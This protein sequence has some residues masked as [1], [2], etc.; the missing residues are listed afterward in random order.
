LMNVNEWHKYSS[1]VSAEFQLTDEEGKE[2][3]RPAVKG[4]HFRILIHAH[5]PTD[6]HGYDWV[7]IEKIEELSH[8]DQSKE[9]IAIRVRPSPT[10]NKKGEN[11]AHFFS[12]S[13]TSS[14]VVERDS[15]TVTA[16]VYG[17][18]E[19]P[20]TETTTLIDKVR[21]AIVGVTAIVGLSNVQWKNLVKG[22]IE[23]P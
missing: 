20:N 5:G 12:D 22:L 15:L 19:I 18:N 2:V 17:R 13:S 16:A 14:F 3:D 9:S 23:T 6:G 8:A 11:V 7:K 1:G 4:D 10:P 21:N